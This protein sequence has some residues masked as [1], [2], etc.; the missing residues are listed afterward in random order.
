MG[1]LKLPKLQIGDRVEVHWL[2]AED[3][4]DSE[5]TPLAEALK[6]VKNAPVE[7]IGFYLGTTAKTLWLFNNR[8]SKNNNVNSRCQ[9][10]K[11]CITKIII[12]E[13]QK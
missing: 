8:E 10:P 3:M 5:W 4:N 1:L 11:G 9:V 12:L 2:D 13:E 6:Q 7:T